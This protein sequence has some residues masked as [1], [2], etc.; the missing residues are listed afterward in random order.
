MR[1]VVLTIFILGLFVGSAFAQGAGQLNGM[2]ADSSGGVIPGVTVFAVESGTGISRDTV[3]GANGRYQFAA[4]RP[5]TYE[6]R[7]ELA[8]F[9]TVRQTDVVLAANQNLTL[10]ITLQLGDL[11]ETVTV[12][13]EAASVD[14]SSATISEVVDSKRIV[15]LPLNGRGKTIPGALRL[16]TNGTESRQASFRLDGTNHTDSYFQQNQP[17][18]FPDALQEFSIQTSNYSAAQGASAGAVVNAV[19]RSGTNNLHGG[20]F[21]YARDR[22]FNSKNFFLPERDFLKRKQYGGYAG[23]PIMRNKLFFFAGWQGT[24]I[25]NVGG[26][27][28]QTVPTTAMR[29]GDFSSFATALRDPL[30]GTF[31]GNQIPV[32]RFDPASVKVLGFMPQATGNGTLQIPRRI[33]QNDNQ[34]IAKV[35]SQLTQNNQVSVRYFFDHFT[36]DPTFEAGNLLTYRNPTLGSRQR[37]QNVVGS[38]QRTLTSTLLNEFRVGYNKFGSSRYPPSGVPSMQ[39]LGVRL[40]IYPSLPSISE[41]QANGFFNIGDN[42]FASFPRH[43]IEINDRVNWAKGRHQIQFGGETA[44]QD[45]KIRNEFRRAGHFQ[46]NGSVT[47]NALAD[48]LLGQINTFDQ[49]T[50]EY[51]DYAV[52]YASGFVQDDFKVSDR[53]TLNMGVRFEHSPPWH[54]VEGRIMHWSVAD[55]NANVRSTMFPAA[56]R[57][58]TFRGDAGFVGEEGV[59]PRANTASARLGFAWDITGDGRTSLRGGGGTFYD[60]RRGGESGNEAVNAPPFSL[61]LNVT[62]PQGPFSDPYRGRTDFAL[63]TDATVGTQQ[64]V[65]PTPV[66]ISTFGSEYKVPL[67]YNFN[68]TFEREVVTGLMARAAYVGS[69]NRNGRYAPQL[70]Y[71]V[72]APGVT[73]ATT[74]ARRL[75]AAAGLGSIGSQAE[76]RQSNYNSMQLTLSKRYSH[77]FTVTSNYTLSKVEGDFGPEIIPYTMPQ[78]QALMWGPL[79]QDHRHRFTTSW[80]LDLPGANMTGP[81]KHVIGG[82]QWT[83]VM[84]YQTG[85]PYTVTSGRDN[86]LDGIGNDR[87]SLTGTSVAP[88]DGSAQT[89]WFNPAA[90]AVNAAGTFGDTG[91]GAYYG[92]SLQSWDMGL[93]K[94]FRMNADMNVQFRAEFFNVFN[95]VN[96]DLPN[97]NVSGANFGRITRTDPGFG[98]PRIIQFGLKFVF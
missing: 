14:I 86:S 56:P 57:G 19:T 23:G 28:T 5:T 60:Q 9:R 21:G 49:G 98:D 66:L 75:Y 89:V 8:G 29:A 76:D 6:I 97:T 37:I 48:F 70:N 27:L 31:P 59:A 87:A 63:I 90:F 85:R 34:I 38:W 10:N 20:V 4:L 79:D 16:S 65:F 26:T 33:G 13:G 44:I 58:E 94:N 52:F 72:Y 11:S 22:T 61:R 84:Q 18:P 43:G 17:F 2:V 50:G 91:K 88:P 82:W 54:E 1:R 64:A 47:G 55:Y 77:G 95:Q 78:N 46:F 24:T 93:F 25:Q 53:L 51:K 73:T 80:V 42:L 74:D 39:D 12:A 36:N 30:G 45:V 3:T 81:L 7:A 92:P 71:A 35:D 83:G 32:S 69:R 67:T 15:E 40:P 62:R 68:L 41:I 96:F